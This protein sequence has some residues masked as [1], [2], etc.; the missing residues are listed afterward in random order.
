MSD[1][2]GLLT[3]AALIARYAGPQ[4]VSSLGVPKA[5]AGVVRIGGTEDERAVALAN[6][7]ESMGPTYVKLAQILASRPDLLS[8]PYRNAL[9]RLQDNVAAM[10]WSDVELTLT[11][12]LGDWDAHFATFERDPLAQPPLDRFIGQPQ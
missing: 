12:E 10:P 4:M 11:E 3:L 5:L 2:P 6:E 9:A 1:S 8:T 7:L